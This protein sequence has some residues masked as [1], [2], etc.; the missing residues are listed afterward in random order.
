MQWHDEGIILALDRF[1]ERQFIA[2][3]F[4][5]QHGVRRGLLRQAGRHGRPY[6][7]ADVVTLSWRARHEDRLG[8]FTMESKR[9]A[10]L[11][12]FAERKVLAMVQSTLGM[13]R[14]FCCES[15]GPSGVV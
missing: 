6:Q 13:I 7:L 4:C 5:K 15:D 14:G 10:P 9:H 1:G 2:T 11:A 8:T 12:M 3:C